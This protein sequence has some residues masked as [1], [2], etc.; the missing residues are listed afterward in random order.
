[1]RSTGLRS[2]S[3]IG[4]AGLLALVQLA[5]WHVDRRVDRL[6]LNTLFLA[7]GVCLIAV[8]L[9][10][11]AALIVIK[12]NAPGRRAAAMLLA[13]M[14]LVPLFLISGAW[15]AGFGIQGWHTLS[16][17]PHLARGPWLAGWRAAIWVHGLAGVPWVTLIVA[18]GLRAVETELEEEASLV[19][20]PA[21]VLWHITLPRAWP[22]ISIAALW[23]AIVTS[24]EISV[25][26]FFQIRTFAEEV[27]TQAVLGTF[28]FN[29]ERQPMA[30]G[31]AGF[32]LG[33]ALSTLL[34]MIALVFARRLF[35][36]FGQVSLRASWTW[37][38][39]AGRWIATGV[40]WLVVLLVA[41]VPMGNLLYKAGGHV[42]QTNAG[43]V[44][45]WSAAKALERVVDAPREFAGDLGLSA[46]IGAAAAGAAVLIGIPLA[47]SL[48]SAHRVPLVRLTGLALCLTIP[49]PLLGIGLIRLLNQPPSSAFAF[50][51]VLYDSHFA[52]WL[53][54]TI[55]ALPLVTL[56]LL[57]ALASVPQATLEAAAID[58]A[59]WWGR[60]LW[61]ALPQRLPAV[62]ASFLVG[63]AVAF[64]E[65]AATVLVVPP[66]RATAIT[67]RVFQLL[68]YG[69]DDRVAAISLVLLGAMGLITA[70][71][72][73]VVGLWARSHYSS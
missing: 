66:G 2:M 35:L 22:A 15:D 28:D 21:R 14:L 55:R 46:G 50:L 42:T 39:G 41:A 47:W 65:L 73:F 64:G 19:A 54:Q 62:A 60:L 34:A 59:G 58:G 37:R 8:P 72:G 30:A 12:T 13:G 17:N 7:E 26:D 1:M 57:A 20:S 16:T 51:G 36:D 70:A 29:S 25:T 61:I 67:V 24:T 33:L 23:V 45:G 9:G 63:L 68:H 69:V 31:T 11:L 10:M 48:R 4:T 40:L 3:L 56:I 5:F 32:W 6:W 49:G 18:A 43:R 44:R 38:I 27:Y 52:P 71:V 53:V